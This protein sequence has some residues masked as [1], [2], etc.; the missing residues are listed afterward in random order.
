MSDKGLRTDLGQKTKAEEG[1]SA[2]PTWKWRIQAMMVRPCGIGSPVCSTKTPAKLPIII[3][4]R[5]AVCAT[6]VWRKAARVTKVRGR[7]C[8]VLF[9]QRTSHAR[10][11]P[12]AMHNS[13]ADPAD[14]LDARGANAGKCAGKRQAGRGSSPTPATRQCSFETIHHSM[15]GGKTQAHNAPKTSALRWGSPPPRRTRS[16][17]S[18]AGSAP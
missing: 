5:I 11:E 1:R 14:R 13:G 10:G 17:S 3:P 16:A 12:S 8:N 18:P 9:P 15:Q 6:K 4:R 7:Q 2:H